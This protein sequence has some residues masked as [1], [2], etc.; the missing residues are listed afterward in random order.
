MT[1]EKTIKTADLTLIS[2][3]N[4]E[5][6]S[7]RFKLEGGRL[8]KIPGGRLVRGTATRLSLSAAALSVLIRRLTPSQALTLGVTRHETARVV[9]AE[10]LRT[11]TGGTD[12]MPTV[13]RTLEHFHSPTGPGWMLIDHDGTMDP[14]VLMD[15]L[16]GVC[17]DLATAP[18]VTYASA[19]SYIYRTSDDECLRGL[20]GHHHHYNHGHYA[21]LISDAIKQ[22]NPMFFT[23]EHRDLDRATKK[24][25]MKGGT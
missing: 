11:A 22:S 13:A 4:P 2:A 6:I 23:V 16:D 1:T 12:T 10:A 17:P 18:R 14:A 9:T 8:V 19:S 21:V 24:K 15:V 3:V 5:T 7:K 25:R 20:T